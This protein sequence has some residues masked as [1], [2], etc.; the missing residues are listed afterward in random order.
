MVPQSEQQPG[1]LGA[2][3]G[4]Q[5][6]GGFVGEQQ[7]GVVDEGAGDRD[8]LLLPAGEP[9]GQGV[10]PPVEPDRRDQLPGSVLPDAAVSRLPRQGGGEDVVQDGEGGAG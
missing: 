5:V 1:D 8:P 3:S 9:G 2:G 4:V 10:L 6:A 7:G